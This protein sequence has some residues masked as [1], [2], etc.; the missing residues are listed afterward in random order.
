MATL[1]TWNGRTAT[2]TA[3]NASINVALMSGVRLDLDH[4][5]QVTYGNNEGAGTYFPPIWGHDH[6]GV[7]S[8]VTTVP[9]SSVGQNELK[10][11]TATGSVLIPAS[12]SNTLTL[13]G[14]T[15]AMYTVSAETAAGVILFGAG[16]TAAGTLG[17]ANTDGATARTAYIDER[18]F[19]ASP[20]YDID[21]IRWGHFLYILHNASGEIFGTYEA[22]DP[23]WANNGA[24]WLPDKNDTER[25]LSAPHPFADYWDRDPALD[26]LEIS[27]FNI[28]DIDID[29]LKLDCL[30]N[31]KKA[32]MEL[33][34]TIKSKL[35]ITDDT[36]IDTKI[37]IPGLNG[38]MKLKDCHA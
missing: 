24:I 9:T 10:T 19:T 36:R 38:V 23:T 25:I 12:G 16:N 8:R 2:Q 37:N 7:N 6:D 35:N 3:A 4:L 33:I 28:K 15:W 32:N 31:K 22:S 20:P 5:R 18:Y 14:G 34:T 11:S 26:G 1:E 21:G 13:T 17:F 27:L 29:K 30:K